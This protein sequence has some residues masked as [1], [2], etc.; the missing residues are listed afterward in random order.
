MWK[1]NTAEIKS[2]M[3]GYNLQTE[4]RTHVQTDRQSFDPT[5]WRKFGY[6]SSNLQWLLS[7]L[8]NMI[9]I[10][11]FSDSIFWCRRTGGHAE[12][13]RHGW[14][15]RYGWSLHTDHVLHSRISQRSRWLSKRYDA[16]WPELLCVYSQ[17]LM[18]RNKWSDST[19]PVNF[20]EGLCSASF[21]KIMYVLLFSRMN[22]VC[23][24]SE[25]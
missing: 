2:Y 21:L 3:Q 22:S 20:S 11:N 18:L 14:G 10:Y 7:K 19:V 13:E 15:I 5:F 8:S 4:V 16:I 25:A 6:I 12:G 9:L 23:L 1:L 17:L 24:H